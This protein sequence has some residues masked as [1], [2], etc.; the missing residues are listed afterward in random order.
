MPLTRGPMFGALMELL[1]R[2]GILPVLLFILI[3]KL[4]D[5][6]MGFMVKP[7]WVDSGFTAAEIGL[8]S[9]NIGLVLSIAGGVAGGWITDRIG[10]FQRAVDP[11]A[12]A[13][14]VEPRLLGRR[15]ASPA[16]ERRASSRRFAAQGDPLRGERDRV[17]HRRARHRPRSS[18]S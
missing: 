2:P 6:A 17:V 14:A 3:F 15:R 4:P 10:I 9:V 7:F 5:A 8:V 13:G 1:S 11:R 16:R 12:R 18:R